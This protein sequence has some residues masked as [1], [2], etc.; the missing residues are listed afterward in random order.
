MSPLAIIAWYGLALLGGHWG[1]IGPYD[2]REACTS[3]MEWLDTQG[4]D[5]E[6]CSMVE[7]GAEAIRLEV[8]EMASP[9]LS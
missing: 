2:S 5:T 9:P 1:L 6:T 4:Y 8:G 7:T 3:V